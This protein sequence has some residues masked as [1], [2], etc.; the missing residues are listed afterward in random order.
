MSMQSTSNGSTRRRSLS[1]WQWD[2]D[3]ATPL[4]DETIRFTVAAPDARTTFDGDALRIRTRRTS[5]PFAASPDESGA[6]PEWG[7]RVT[8]KA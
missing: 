4:F 5:R 7:V 2:G 8:R 6:A 1:I 3:D